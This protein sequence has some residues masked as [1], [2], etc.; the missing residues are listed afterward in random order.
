MILIKN[1]DNM[2]YKY[3]QTCDQLKNPCESSV[4]QYEMKKK[5]MKKFMAFNFSND[6]LLYWE[7]F[8]ASYF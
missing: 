7:S 8:N 6:N 1:I 2:P 5:K 4:I 3:P